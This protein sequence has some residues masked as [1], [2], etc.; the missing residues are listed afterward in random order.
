MAAAYLTFCITNLMLLSE[1]GTGYGKARQELPI[2]LTCRYF[3][4][5]YRT[6]SVFL[7]AGCDKAARAYFNR[8]SVELSPIASGQKGNAS[9]QKGNAS[10]QH[11]N[12]EDKTEDTDES[13]NRR[14]QVE[15]PKL[16]WRE[17]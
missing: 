3:R 7:I 2:L 6:G 15:G 12:K 11:R 13:N 4:C 10:D 5:A 1:H 9:G 17:V 14:C 8:L 16:A